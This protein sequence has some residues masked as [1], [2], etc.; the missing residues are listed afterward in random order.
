MTKREICELV[1]EVYRAAY[2][3]WWDD[4]SSPDYYNP[5]GNPDDAWDEYIEPAAD[6]YEEAS[7]D[8]I[9]FWRDM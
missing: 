6:M 9:H 1:R 5:P 4:G 8:D 2:H 7:V 3:Q